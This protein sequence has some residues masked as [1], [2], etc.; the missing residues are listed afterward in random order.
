MAPLPPDSTARLKVHYAVC[1]YRHTH[2]VRFKSPNT[3]DDAISAFNGLIAIIG[4]SFFSSE[5]VKLEVA[6]DGS[7]IF[8]PVADEALAGWGSGSGTPKDTANMLNFIGRSLDGRKAR[9][10]LFG[11]TITSAGGD[12]RDSGGESSSVNDAV[13]YLNGQEGCYIT[14]NGFQ[15]IWYD[16]VN[17]GPN[18]YWRN[19]IRA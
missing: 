17:L 5:I 12:Y 10:D 3:V 9:A 13:A 11:C 2:Q 15:P 7:N 1:G 18:A 19:K 4:G 6:A 8:N 14:I 16:Y